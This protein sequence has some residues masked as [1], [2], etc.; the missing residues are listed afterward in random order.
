[1]ARQV[2]GG[3][4]PSGTRSRTSRVGATRVPTSDEGLA[5]LRVRDLMVR[6]L[7][8]V[9]QDAGLGTAE[10]LMR[11]HRLRHLP[12]LEGKDLKGLV[13]LRDVLMHRAAEIEGQTQRAAS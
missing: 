1:M 9:K 13:S 10:S 2:S 3:R 12:V 4:K 6:A 11:T 8:T 5:S 7:V